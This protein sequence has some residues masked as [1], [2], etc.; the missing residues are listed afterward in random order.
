MIKPSAV[1]LGRFAVFEQGKGRKTC[2]WKRVEKR[3]L[4]FKTNT[5]YQRFIIPLNEEKWNMSGKA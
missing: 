4:E 2:E 1:H 3:D 5:D